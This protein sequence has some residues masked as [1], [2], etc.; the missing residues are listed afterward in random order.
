MHGEYLTY[1][2]RNAI[3]YEAEQ[4]TGDI[5]LVKVLNIKWSLLISKGLFI[6]E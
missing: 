2:I 5:C 3:I 6:F 4:K 1:F